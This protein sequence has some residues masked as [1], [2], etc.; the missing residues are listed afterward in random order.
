MPLLPSRAELRRRLPRVV[1]GLVIF[2]LGIALL[3]RSDIGLAPWDVL[4]QGL[5]DRTGIPIGTVGI[6]V[7]LPVLALWW[8]VGVRPG[9]GTVLNVFVVG[10]TIDLA[11]S[12]LPEVGPLPA[13]IALMVGGVVAM[14]FGSGLYIG[15]GLGPGP[16]DGLM[17]GLQARGYA[18]VRTARTGIELAVMLL[19][20][21]LGGTIGPGTVV[22]A[23]AIGPLVQFFLHRFRLP[24]L[25]RRDARCL[26][27]RS[28]NGR[29]PA[30][31]GRERRPAA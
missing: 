7:G 30:G 2:G 1:V 23:L 14:G 19:G 6:L 25:T 18:S 29:P 22:Q 27:G 21:S 31:G 20:W 5:S 24:P 28:P 26:L 11:L 4:H 8:P 16:R 17:V 12:L 15:A 3:V 10:V 9:I 13:Q